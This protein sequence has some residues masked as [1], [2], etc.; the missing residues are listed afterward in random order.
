MVQSKKV[1]DNLKSLA[2]AHLERVDR[3]LDK[4][5]AHIN[6]Q[7]HNAQNKEPYLALME[8]HANKVLAE[9]SRLRSSVKADA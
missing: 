2:G 9:V 4:V 7:V 5:V 6:V 1:Q 3:T 8:S